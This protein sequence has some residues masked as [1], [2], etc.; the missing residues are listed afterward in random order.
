MHLGLFPEPGR[1]IIAMSSPLPLHCRQ[2]PRGPLAWVRSV[3]MQGVLWL[4]VV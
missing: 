2:L 1:A 4:K 3:K